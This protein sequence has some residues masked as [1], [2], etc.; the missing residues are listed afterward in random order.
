MPHHVDISELQRRR[1]RLEE[2]LEHLQHQLQRLRTLRAH[3]VHQQ[4]ELLR[5]HGPG[6]Q[7]D[8]LQQQYQELLKLFVATVQE[9]AIIIDL[10]SQFERYTGDRVPTVAT[11]SS[12]W[13]AASIEQQER[14]PLLLIPDTPRPPKFE[15]DVKSIDTDPSIHAPN[16]QQSVLSRKRVGPSALFLALLLLLV[17]CLGFLL[18]ALRLS[19][20]G[21]STVATTIPR[22][23][24]TST[25]VLSPTASTLYPPVAQSYAGEIND[26][27]VADTK[28]KLYLTQIK[29]D[30]NRISG[31]F[32]GLGL[33]GT[34]TGSVTSSGRVHFTVKID[35]G[36]LILDGNIK[37]G[38]DI[39]GTFK[40][41]DQQGQSL[42][43]YGDWN[44]SV[45]PSRASARVRP[46]PIRMHLLSDLLV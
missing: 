44:V 42:G 32:Q 25:P 37:V 6:E 18:Y 5:Q 7:Y 11:F 3:V 19:P 2:E 29:Q 40:A 33:V 8:E 16:E 34:F 24:L 39:R 17:L 26:I 45:I 23:A 21:P 27:G 10:L 20:H 12:T 41:V 46:Y 1:A 13:R 43:E 35:A 30:Q 4:N 31:N 9:R 15:Q 36:M 38:G 22:S 28:T 14:W